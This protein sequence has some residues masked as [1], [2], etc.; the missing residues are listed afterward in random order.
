VAGKPLTVA[1]YASQAARLAHVQDLL[2]QA[3]ESLRGL[4]ECQEHSRATLSVV[5][6][7][8]ALH[9]LHD[10]LDHADLV[11]SDPDAAIDAEDYPAFMRALE[12]ALR[13]N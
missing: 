7:Q 9:R 13:P 10:E 4:P 1:E 12:Q 3:L 6:A 2:A 5:N 11:P 8:H